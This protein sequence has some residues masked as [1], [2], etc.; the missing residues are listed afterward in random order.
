MTS[1]LEIRPDD[2]RYRLRHHLVA[3]FAGF[4][5]SPSIDAITGEVGS[6]GAADGSRS[7]YAFVHR[8]ALQRDRD[9]VFRFIWDNRSALGLCNEAYTEVAAVR[10]CLRV[11]RRRL[12]AAGDG[13]RLRA[14]PH[15]PRR[16]A[17]DH[18]D[19]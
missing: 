3:G 1:D 18:P 4:G 11:G 7:N 16:R 6:L 17:R 10:P 5:F 12:Y 8:E 15:R 13:C 19:S 14:D 9:E 2:R